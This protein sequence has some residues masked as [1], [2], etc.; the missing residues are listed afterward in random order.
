MPEAP[1]TVA[2]SGDGTIGARTVG[3]IPVRNIWL[4]M[5]YASE[6]ARFAGEAWAH[7]EEDAEQLPDLV[8]ELL[9]AAVERRLRRNLISG[10][11]FTHE[12]LRRVRGRI[13]MLTTVRHRL[14]ERGQVACH[15]EQLTMDTPRNRF[16]RSSL[17][18]I[19]RLVSRLELRTTCRDLAHDFALL[20]VGAQ[21]PGAEELAADRLDRLEADDRL[22]MVLAQLAY[23]LALPA[24]EA[25]ADWMFGPTREITWVRKL[26]EKAVAGFYAVALEP[27]GWNVRAGESLHWPIKAGT[28]GVSA[29]LPGMRS[30][31]ILD[32][33]SD[34]RRIVIDTKFN[35]IVTKGWHRD[36]TLRSGY[37]YQIYAYLRSQEGEP[38]A[39]AAEG[40]LL[41]PSVDGEI[42]DEA[43]QIQGHLIRFSTVDL[44]LPATKIRERLLAVVENAIQ[45]R[46]AAPK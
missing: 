15:F 19:A 9:C 26:Y 8:A 37:L 27:R 17:E 46:L 32:R 20:G 11:R 29:I 36:E 39:D 42:V 16:V 31:I 3:R 2:P 7:L 41:H 22:M 1:T 6:L 25:G 24:D 30:D 43:V 23:D 28:A 21:R 18:S 35:A 38:A 33:V 12:V 44:S 40:L 10:Y 45:S 13:D 14:L 4:L 34:R 5:L